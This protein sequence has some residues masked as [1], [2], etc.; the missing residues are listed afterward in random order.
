MAVLTILLATSLARRHRQITSWTVPEVAEFFEEGGH[1]TAHALA[2]ANGVD[3]KTLR[4]LV[5]ADLV[6]ADMA[7]ER[8]LDLSPTAGIPQWLLP[9]QAPL[10]PPNP[11]TTPS[12][13]DKLNHAISATDS[14][15]HEV[16]VKLSAAPVVIVEKFCDYHRSMEVAMSKAVRRLTPLRLRFTSRLQS[17][18]L[19]AATTLRWR[20]HS[21][22]KGRSFAM[23]SQWK[24]QLCSLMLCFGR[25]SALVYTCTFMYTCTC[26]H[27]QLTAWSQISS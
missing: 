22:Q 9:Q 13:R 8:A 3:G 4:R 26:I 10:P 6:G 27:A 21:Q 17:I 2:I 12:P 23:T 18:C 16:Q 24:S 11:D 19:T 20:S 5:R 7:L 25:R 1:R 14:R 15:A